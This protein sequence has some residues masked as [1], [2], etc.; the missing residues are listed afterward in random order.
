MFYS[1]P[2]KLPGEIKLQVVKKIETK[3]EE[4]KKLASDPHSIISSKKMRRWTGLQIVKA[5][6]G[7]PIVPGK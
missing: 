1:T 2:E 6:L 3:R 7:M 5:F 4:L